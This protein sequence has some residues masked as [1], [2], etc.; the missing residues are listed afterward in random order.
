MEKTYRI[1]AGSWLGMILF[2]SFVIA[3]KVFQVFPKAQAVEFQS[4]IFP[5]YY[6]IGGVCG[7][8]LFFVDL[9][10]GRGKLIAIS[11]AF[12]LT[13]VGLTVLTPLIRDAYATQSTAMQ[14]LHP[15][16]IGLN[17]LMLL[18]VLIA[19]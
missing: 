2:F 5:L 6:A 18:A 8:G 7:F 11:I 15:L 13:I 17:V 3:P 14:W 9:L 16:A 12:A 10:R 1:L 19:V 4:R